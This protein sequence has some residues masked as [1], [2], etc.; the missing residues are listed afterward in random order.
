MRDALTVIDA[1]RILWPDGTLAP[2]RLMYSA[3]RID[4]LLPLTH[5]IPD[6]AHVV[7]RAG[8]IVAPGFVDTHV[9]GGMGHNFMD[10]DTRSSARI[11][12]Y[13]AAGG[14][15][16][17]LAATASTDSEG[18]AASLEALSR[19][20]GRLGPQGIELLGIH[21]EGPFLSPRYHGVHRTEWLQ[22]PSRERIDAVLSAA[23]KSLKLVTLAPE[24]PGGMDA[25]RRLVDAGVRVSIGHSGAS[26]GEAREAVDIGVTRVTHTFNGLPSIHHRE[27][28]PL[29]VLLTDPRVF[30]ELVADGKH[31]VPSMIRFLAAVVGPDRIV[32]V[33][34]GTDVA[35]L[36]DGRARRW[37]GTEVVL[38]HGQAM[39]VSG[40]MAGSVARIA[41]MVRVVV[42]ESGISLQQALR[43]A[44][45]NPARSLGLTDRGS[46]VPGTFA[47]IVI[48]D[49]DLSVRTTIAHGDVAYSKDEA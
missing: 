47:D 9:H 14:V 20:Q 41:D 8:C 43:M 23:G 11:G 37:E 45:L 2:G 34:D 46:F 17:C 16:S 13:L 6:S 1:D 29:P 28:G 48:L 25:I 36:P 5:A 4:S 42:S 31:V 12:A 19:V 49:P 40:T 38:A 24:L 3:G 35:G 32:L 7:D 15:T 26:D 27:P 39:T 10:R 33:S 22:T 44:S 21:L 18:L 30:C